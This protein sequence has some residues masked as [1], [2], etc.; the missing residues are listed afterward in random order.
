MVFQDPYTSLNPTLTIA[1]NAAEPLRVRGVPAKERRE[2]V[3]AIFE[4]VGLNRNMLDR[5]PGELSGGQLQRVGIARALSIDPRVLILDEPVSALDVSV[6]AQILNLLR[7]LQSSRN[8]AYLF[9]SH[10]MAVVRYISHRVAV[11]YLGRIVESG[12]S[13]DVLANPV[14]PY[15]EGMIAAVPEIHSASAPSRQLVSEQSR[16]HMAAG[17]C[18]FAPRCPLA[19]PECRQR[20]P[21]L[22]QVSPHHEVA[23]LVRAPSEREHSDK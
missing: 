7:R 21:H 16:Q 17:G 3:A 13:H 11:M 5:L 19:V 22:V 10:D 12:P 6:Q 8:L 23:C 14:H 2:R 18:R 4:E 9:I 15:T 20:D 1:A